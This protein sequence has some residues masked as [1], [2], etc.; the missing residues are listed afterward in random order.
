MATLYY[1]GKA[2][3][4]A[5]VSQVEVGT[6]DAATTYSL[7]VNGVSVTS[8]AAGNADAVAAA[9]VAA[10]NASTHPYFSPITAAIASGSP[11]DVITLTSDEAGFPFTA[12]ASVSGGSG[13]I[14]SVTTT[15]AATGPHH[16]DDP[17]NYSN[18]AIPDDG[19]TVIIDKSGT[20]LCWNLDRSGQSPT[21]LLAK[22]ITRGDVR[23]GLATLS[24][25]TSADGETTSTEAPE[26][27]DDY[28]SIGITATEIG[29]NRNT[30]TP[31]GSGRMKINNLATAA[32]TCVVSSTSATAVETSLP[33]V[34]LKAAS[35]NFDV[36]V[37][38]ARA[39]VGIGIEA[40]ETATV[41]DVHLVDQSSVSQLFIG[42]GVTHSSVTQQGGK[43]E[44]DAAATMPAITINGGAATIRGSQDVTALNV[45]GGAVRCNTTGTVA[46]LT[47]EGGSIDFTGES[48]ART[49]TDYNYYEGAR[50]ID[51]GVLTITNDN[52]TGRTVEN[53]E[54]L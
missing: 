2:Q 15:T 36:F 6:Y 13:T 18:S 8:L 24:V 49:V 33:A 28:L 17:D 14:G 26:Y 10:W 42:S 32:A 30:S 45:N 37:E 47:Q 31:T 35:A 50:S 38:S 7:I 25:A 48:R 29:P 27:R 16:I 51:H 23:I 44:I 1:T 11:S 3:A 12:S 39:G 19:D 5:Q 40:G 46:T 21:V 34:R 53:Q 20:R 9:L 22:F 41:G 52:R 54:A 43:S 4:V